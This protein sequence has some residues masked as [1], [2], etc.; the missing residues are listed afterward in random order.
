MFKIIGNS[1][2]FTKFF[3]PPSALTA[4]RGGCLVGFRVI[5]KNKA[6]PKSKF[7]WVLAQLFCL[8]FLNCG[9]DLNCFRSRLYLAQTTGN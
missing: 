7:E 8:W 5:K 3:V 1:T 9:D 6:V 4:C 2:T